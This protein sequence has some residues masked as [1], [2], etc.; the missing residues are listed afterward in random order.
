M[1][2]A[3]ARSTHDAPAPAAAAAPGGGTPV[4]LLY[5][6]NVL[7]RAGAEEHILTLVQ[8]LDRTR[9]RIHLACPPVVAEKLKPDLPTDVE[10]IPLCLRRPTHLGAARRLASIIRTRRVDILHSHLFYSSLFASPIGR[11]CRVP[12][13]VE[14]PHVREHWRRGWKSSF[15]VDRLVG[16]CVDTYVAVSK[17][18]ARYLTQEKRLPD[19]KVVVIEN[20]C[21][22]ARFD[23]D[24]LPPA[25]LKK[26][27]EFGESDLVLVVAARLEPQKGHR[28]LLEAL[29]A[30]LREFATVRLVCVG[31]GQLRPELEALVV[32]LGLSASVR[33]VG[34]RSDVADW[35]ALADMTVLPSFYEGLPLAAI[36]SLAVARPVV[37]TAVDGTPEVVLHE[38]NGL[39]VPPGDA[40]ALAE[41]I[42]RLL[43][44]SRMR[45]DLGRAGRDWVLTRFNQERQVQRTQDLY[46]QA[47]GTRRR[48]SSAPS[49]Q[50]AYG[51]PQ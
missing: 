33:F 26:S 50:A 18:N 27:L 17:A 1:F 12:L 44:D 48:R 5:F 13:I 25:G 47:L 49:P 40:R 9:F 23:P 3:V 36:E 16:R 10:L 2:F 34:Y 43:R 7:V 46:L 28:V 24:R 30:V 15:L 19:R 20:G 35:L 37:A 39:I 32:R 51:T 29:P 6:T 8:G 14:T 11:A 45:R 31:D 4:N 38:R 21:D 41:A 22:L 42:C